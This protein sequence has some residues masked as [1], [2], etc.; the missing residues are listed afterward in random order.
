M[1]LVT[2]GLGGLGSIA[3]FHVAAEGM[4]PIVTTSRTGKMPQSQIGVQC[5]ESMQEHC[6]HINAKLDVGS[7]FN[8]HDAME[9]LNKMNQPGQRNQ[10]QIVAIENVISQLR[11]QVYGL[12]DH[13]LRYTLEMVQGMRDKYVGAIKKIEGEMQKRRPHIPSTVYQQTYGDLLRSESQVSDLVANLSYKLGAKEVDTDGVKQAGAM[14]SL[15]IDDLDSTSL[16]GNTQQLA[17]SGKQI[18]ERLSGIPVSNPEAPGGLLAE[19]LE[20]AELNL[21]DVMSPSPCTYCGEFGAWTKC[22][23][24]DAVYCGRKCQKKDWKA[25]K[26]VCSGQRRAESS[27]EPSE[28]PS[29]KHDAEIRRE[30]PK[31][32]QDILSQHIAGVQS[33]LIAGYTAGLTKSS[34]RRSP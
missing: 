7:A 23:A 28:K 14:L 30:T 29:E 8:M 32:I 9:Y 34:G 27:A 5:F 17:F 31:H 3:S 21:N 11:Q 24:C 22:G 33:G 2:G 16:K 1:S 13:E 15:A 18:E 6:Y 4:G 19:K 10:T 26:M 12:G 25:H 20:G